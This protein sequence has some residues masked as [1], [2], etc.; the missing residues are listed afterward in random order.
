[1]LKKLWDQQY[2]TFLYF[3]SSTSQVTCNEQ[4][5]TNDSLETLQPSCRNTISI[6]SVCKSNHELREEGENT[7]IHWSSFAPFLL[8]GSESTINLSRKLTQISHAC[9]RGTFCSPF[10]GLHCLCPLQPLKSMSCW[11]IEFSALRS[12]VLTAFISYSNDKNR[13][14]AVVWVLGKTLENLVP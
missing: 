9:F 7:C 4:N 2:G 12:R 10:S 13:T 14:S 11:C 6:C 1:M 8:K 5:T 3:I